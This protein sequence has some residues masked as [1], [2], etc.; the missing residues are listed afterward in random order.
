MLVNLILVRRSSIKQID[1]KKPS[2]LY[3]KQKTRELRPIK[4]NLINIKK[5][6][7]LSLMAAKPSLVHEIVSDL[8]R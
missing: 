6:N 1:F 3:K 7:P 8:K 4:P 5:A 2:P